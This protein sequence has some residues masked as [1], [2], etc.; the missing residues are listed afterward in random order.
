[1]D[2]NKQINLI[3]GRQIISLQARLA[4]VKT[5]GEL[6]KIASDLNSF[7]EAGHN[8]LILAES[9]NVVAETKAQ[10][11]IE[12]TENDKSGGKVH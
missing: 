1:M 4:E 2:M 12:M 3:A 9:L 10:A 11:W 5:I 6:H 7:A 8:I